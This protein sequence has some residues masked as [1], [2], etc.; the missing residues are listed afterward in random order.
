MGGGGVKLDQS[1]HDAD[2]MDFLDAS[3]PRNYFIFYW[4]N[5]VFG[6]K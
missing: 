2:K 1:S 4:N 3:L 6:I 5:F